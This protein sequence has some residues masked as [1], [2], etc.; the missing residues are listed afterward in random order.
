LNIEKQIRED[1]HAHL[2]VQVDADRLE[3]MKRRAASQLA[4]RVKIAGFRPGKAPY[5][6]IVRQLGE[7]AILEEAIELLVDDIYPDV[8]KEAEIKPYGPGKLE[9]ISSADPIILEFSVPLEA[10]TILGDYHSISKPYEL[11][12]V[13]DQDVHDVMQDLRERHAIIEP[14]DRQ[15][16][17][18]DLVTLKLSAIRLNTDED[19]AKELIHERSSTIL[20]QPSDINRVSDADSDATSEDKA[21]EWPFPGFSQLL[22]GMGVNDQKSIEFTYPEDSEYQAFKGAAAQFHIQIE[23]VKSRQLPELDDE[24]AKTIGEY[25]SL[26]MLQADVRKSLETQAQSAYNENYDEEIL[27][28]AIE[29]SSFKYPDEMVEHEIETV[30]SEFRRRLERQGM[31]LDLYLKTRK[32][33]MNGFKEEVRPVAEGRIKRALF[34]VEFGKVENIEVKPEELENEAYSTMN[35]LYSTLSEQEARKLSDRDIYTNIVGNVLADMLSRRSLERFRE[36]CSGGL[37]KLPTEDNV[38]EGAHPSDEDNAMNDE[39]E[40]DPESTTINDTSAKET[41]ASSSEAE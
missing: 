29:L 37:S 13:S 7:A 38:E 33:E 3:G 30:I 26:D 17:V 10:E 21:E 28:A 34:L 2:T 24:F 5:P 18:G 41:L 25:D 14:V 31:D 32:L 23:A 27:D 1:H 39:V 11:E 35:Y 36:I 9:N 6:V 12:T 16:Q 22:V 20:I 4:K 8:I 19:D 40:I 15:A